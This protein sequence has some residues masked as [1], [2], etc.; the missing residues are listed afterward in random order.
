MIVPIRHLSAALT[1]ALAGALALALAGCARK[2]EADDSAAAPSQ[3][4][5]P[6]PAAAAS[7]APATAPATPAAPVA[8]KR[9]PR[10]VDIGAGTCIPCKMM[11][12]ILEELQATRAHQFE[13]VF[14]D[15]NHQRDEAT[16]YRIR[17]IPTQIF[18]DEN[19]NE[20]SRHEGF[21]SKEQILGAWN[22]LGYDFGG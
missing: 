11:K 6:T 19:G 14:I 5:I 20:R 17:V 8:E 4:A 2:T 1:F 9:L 15:L 3:Q 22:Q 10:L 21:M 12:P 7:A 13:T 16:R 18:F